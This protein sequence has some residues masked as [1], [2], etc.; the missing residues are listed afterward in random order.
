MFE[1]WPG[2]LS[3]AA[4]LGEV[5]LSKPY[6]VG[7][8]ACRFVSLLSWDIFWRIVPQCD[9][10]DLLVVRDGR[11]WP[12]PDPRTGTEGLEF[13]KAGYSLVLRHA[14]RHDAGLAKLA[15]DFAADFGAQVAI[16]LYATPH[17]HH[18]FGWHY[19]AE[20]VF[21]VQTAGTK[22]YLLREN[23]IRP[24]PLLEAMPKDMEV[25][26]EVSPVI[27]CD[28]VPGDWLYVPAGFWHVARALEDSLSISIGVAAPTAMDLFD[29]LRKHFAASAI[30][31]RRLSPTG[32]QASL[33]AELFQEATRILG[34]PELVEEAIDEVRGKHA[35]RGGAAKLTASV[36]TTK[37]SIPCTSK[38]APSEEVPRLRSRLGG[39]P[40]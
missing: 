26:K 20:E 6:S 25:D 2:T 3:Q 16:Q 22:R 17:E 30:W 11:L 33:V 9:P 7:Q 4:F 10:S 12:G 19:D 15:S 29:E 18:S 28:L 34:D 37:T 38:V 31:R 8:G 24:R 21:I 23:T 40:E 36:E 27:R 14:E 35:Q 5:Y 13:F 39:S 1:H 32:P